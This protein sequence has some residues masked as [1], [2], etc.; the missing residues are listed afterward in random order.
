MTEKIRQEL[1][2]MADGEY[3]IFSAS[4][5]PNIE[6][7]SV[8]GV[9][10]PILR[11][12]AKKIFKEGKYEEFLSGIP[13]LY[14]EE[15]NLHTFIVE[16]IKDFNEAI[17][18]TEKFLPYIDN[19]AT[20]DMF[21]PKTFKKN[22]EELLKYIKKWIKSDKTYTVRYAVKLL[23]TLYLDED[24]DEEFMSFVASVCSDEYYV[25]MMVSGYFAT[26]LFKQPKSALF[27]IEEKKLPIWVH[28]KSI[29]KARESKR[30]SN[31]M[32]EYLNSLKI[33]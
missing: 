26:A 15:N 17:D 20:C 28:N 11:S 29:Q 27:Y 1:R 6:K 9:R 33:K 19:W 2:R 3:K 5:M 14:F 21:M 30:I 18:E 25:N 22:K 31:E 32:K 13:H 8:L 24:F 16:H 23:M 7:D 12:Y 10:V 4:L